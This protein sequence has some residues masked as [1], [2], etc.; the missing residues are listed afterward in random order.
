ML[1]IL[2][3]LLIFTAGFGLGYLTRAWRSHQRRARRSMYLPYSTGPGATTFGHAR[4]A[5]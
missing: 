1:A 4:R 3:L 5:F 2:I